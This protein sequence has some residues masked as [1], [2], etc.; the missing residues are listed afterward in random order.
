M[1]NLTGAR[2]ALATDPARADEALA[3][4]EVVGRDSL[5]SI[6]QVMGLLRDPASGAPL[7]QP[8]LGRHPRPRRRL[9][10]GRASTSP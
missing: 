6:R 2:K 7:P 8:T 3:R 10:R 4:A 1:L 5:D 9:P